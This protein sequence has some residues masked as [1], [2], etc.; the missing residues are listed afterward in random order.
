[1]TS[2]LQYNEGV[3]PDD[4]LTEVLESLNEIEDEE[5]VEPEA[6]AEDESALEAPAK[7]TEELSE[8]DKPDEET[9]PEEEAKAEDETKSP[10]AP[11]EPEAEAEAPTEPEAEAEPQLF[12]V[13]D[14]QK[15]TAEELHE[16]Y[17]NWRRAYTQ[18]RQQETDQLRQAEEHREQRESLYSSMVKDPTMRAFIGQYPE[19]LD[20]LLDKGEATR[21]ILG[22]EAEIRRLW[23]RWELAQD[24]PELKRALRDSARVEE[25]EGQLATAEEQRDLRDNLNA[26]STTIGTMAEEFEGVDVNV[27][28]QYVLDRAGL[29]PEILRGDYG[30]EPFKQGLRRI[31]A[32]YMKPD[33][34]VDKTLI[35]DRFELEVMRSTQAESTEAKKVAEHNAAVDAE[36][37]AAE[38]RPAPTPTGS[39]PASGGKPE[40]EEWAEKFEKGEADMSDFMDSI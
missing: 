23:N 1:M 20:S 26:V 2:E 34:S 19:A 21:R 13:E 5:V 38:D 9:T 16:R 31:V 22:D 11:T 28:N 27:V 6:E 4:A 30:D 37:E 32:M 15:V 10:E 3:G 8:Q 14:G 40:D 17:L 24:D 33:G 7:E 36:L 35:R 29:T 18:R 25:A 12:E 39:A